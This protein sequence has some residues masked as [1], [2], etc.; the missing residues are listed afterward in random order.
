[1]IRFLIVTTT[2]SLTLWEIDAAR[3]HERQEL[4][5]HSIYVFMAKET[6]EKLPQR[7]SFIKY[8]SLIIM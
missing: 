4:A 8:F 7:I 1:M 3:W 2:F 5:L 6:M